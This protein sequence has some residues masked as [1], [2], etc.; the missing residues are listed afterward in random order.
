MVTTLPVPIEFSLP[1]GWRS[2][3]PDDVDSPDAAFVALHPEKTH[4][5]F[6][7]NIAITGEVHEDNVTL[8]QLA[9]TEVERL[10]EGALDVRLGRRNEIGNEEDPGLTQAVKLHVN[11]QGRPQDVYQYQVFLVMRDRQDPARRG[12]LQVVLSALPEQFPT[13]IEDFQQFL[14]SITPESAQ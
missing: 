6:T 9:D 10:R 8:V 13:V 4:E 5:G 7:P 14:S 11:L 2:V 1:P 3:P 12:V